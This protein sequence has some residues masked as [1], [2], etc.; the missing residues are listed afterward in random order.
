MISCS[1]ATRHRAR[2]L[3]GALGALLLSACGSKATP[4]NDAAPPVAAAVASAPDGAALYARCATCHQPTG[5]GLPGNY[6]P[7]AKSEIANGPASIPIRIV[8]KGLQGPI[9]VHGAKYNGIMPPYG[10]GIEMSDAEVAAVLTYVRSQ[11]GNTGGPVTAAE[12]ATERTAVQ[13]RTTPWTAAELGLT[14]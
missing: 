3:A 8:L 10:I 7:L 14:P 1:R 13:S 12:V 2:A 11:W 5:L 4:A 9:T 6:P